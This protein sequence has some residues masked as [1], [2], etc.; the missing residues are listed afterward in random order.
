MCLALFRI[1]LHTCS[2]M[3]EVLLPREKLEDIA[4]DDHE[5][6]LPESVENKMGP[7]VLP[8]TH[9][10]TI[11]IMFE[12]RY[13]SRVFTQKTSSLKFRR[14]MGEPEYS[15]VIDMATSLSATKAAASKTAQQVHN[16]NWVGTF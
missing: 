8:R 16:N 2:F 6:L 14:D 10:H 7:L 12:N 4:L 1:Q 11:S 5:A 13:T 15:A 9:A 3:A